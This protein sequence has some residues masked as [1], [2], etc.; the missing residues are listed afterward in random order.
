MKNNSIIENKNKN[1]NKNDD[2]N[3]DK[4]ENY[5]YSTRSIILLN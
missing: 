3:D 2:D 5:V 1:K 4:S